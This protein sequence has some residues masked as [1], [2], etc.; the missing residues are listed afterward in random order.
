MCTSSSGVGLRRAPVPAAV[1]MLV[2]VP[3]AP[4]VFAFAL[5]TDAGLEGRGVLEPAYVCVCCELVRVA[6][7]EG[8]AAGGR[9]DEDDCHVDGGGS[10]C[11]SEGS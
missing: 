8:A 2:L 11:D 9:E 1:P 7:V 5:V 4:F 6:D 3:G 10:G